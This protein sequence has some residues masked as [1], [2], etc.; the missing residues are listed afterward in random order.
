MQSKI[1]KS[2]SYDEFKK[3]LAD[4]GCRLCSLREKRTTI[5]VDRGNA[6]AKIMMVGEAPGETEDRE[7]RAFVGRA[8]KLLDQVSREVGIDTEQDVL[9]ANIAKCR[10]P[11]NRP[12]KREEIEACLPY[13]QKQIEFIDPKIIILLGRTALK[14]LLPHIKETAMKELVGNFFENSEYPGRRFFLCYHPAYILRDPR[15]KP[16]MISMLKKAASSAL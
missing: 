11:D 7:G 10:P 3:L 16:D 5:V 12:P 2:S 9:I 13:L 8:G 4:S 15:R 1:L 14:A 6:L